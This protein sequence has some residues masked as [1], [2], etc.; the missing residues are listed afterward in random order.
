MILNRY[1]LKIVLGAI[2]GVTG[3]HIVASFSYAGGG[4]ILTD[5]FKP[6]GFGLLIGVVPGVVSRNLRK[7]IIIALIAGVVM[8]VGHYAYKFF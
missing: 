3:I 6:F 7:T 4:S 8:V 1:I 5:Y 2:A